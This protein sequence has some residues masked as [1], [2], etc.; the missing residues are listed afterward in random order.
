VAFGSSRAA[1]EWGTVAAVPACVYLLR[2]RDD[3]LYCGWTSDL[4]RRLRAHAAGRASRYT[5]SRRPLSLALVL[6]MADFSAARREEAR[7]KRLTK[8]QKESFVLEMARVVP[9]PD[10][11]ALALEAQL[12]DGRGA[13]PEVPAA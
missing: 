3:S 8:G 2:C 6:P 12:A 1:E 10:H 5:A 4:E 9:Q 11:A 7:L 13:Q